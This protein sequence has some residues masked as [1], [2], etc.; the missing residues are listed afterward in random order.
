VAI[1]FGSLQKMWQ[2]VTTAALL[3]FMPSTRG[4]ESLQRMLPGRVQD[5]QLRGEFHGARIADPKVVN[6]QK[7]TFVERRLVVNGDPVAKD[8]IAKFPFLVSTGDDRYGHFC[9]GSL[10][11][12]EW[13][14]TAAHCTYNPGDPDQ[15]N[16]WVDLNRHDLTNSSEPFLRRGISFWTQHPEYDDYTFHNDLALYKLDTPVDDFAPVDLDF[17]GQEVTFESLTELVGWGSL[18]VQCRRYPDLLHEGDSPVS[19]EQQCRNTVGNQYYDPEIEL[20][21]GFPRGD[22]EAGCGDSGGPLVL[23]RDDGSFV[24]GGVVSWG[25]GRTWSVYVRVAG[26]EEWITSTIAAN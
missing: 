2:L 26:F 14:L 23:Q 6:A 21:A 24:Q 12:R 7:Q 1:D 9:G 20:C 4:H 13:V 22:I 8:E 17:G 10:I 3:A 15:M 11:H 25:Y 5:E 16:V 19:T 18:D